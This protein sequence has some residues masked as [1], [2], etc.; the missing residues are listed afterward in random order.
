MND[1]GT[2]AANIIL[3]EFDNDLET[4]PLSHVSGWLEAN[5]GQLN[6]LTHEDFWISGGNFQPTGL[7]EVE[8]AIFTKLYT[9]NYYNRAA[10]EAL[11]SFTYASSGVD[12]I[13]LKEGDTTIQRQNKNAVSRTFHEYA[14][15]EKQDLDQLLHQYN[16]S[17]S[18]A[19][20]VAGDDTE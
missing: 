7:E 11:R 6:G 15:A 8:K 9:I 5:V 18:S 4:F 3:F 1:L 2:L 14:R 19:L 16:M 17:K 13:L 20:Q 12:W 10:R